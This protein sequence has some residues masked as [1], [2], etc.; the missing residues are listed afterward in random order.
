MP[1]PESAPR[2]SPSSETSSTCKATT[3]IP[4]PHLLAAALCTGLAASLAVR[5]ASPLLGVLALALAASAFGE[6]RIRLV[7]LGAALLCTGLWWGS[8]RLDALDHSV[9][10]REIGRAGPALLEVTGPS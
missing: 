7:G 4:A 3:R 10:S 6:P 9:L 1:S 8:V 5:I 2:R